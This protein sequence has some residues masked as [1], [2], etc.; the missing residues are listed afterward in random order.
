VHFY[1]RKTSV[2]HLRIM[3]LALF[4]CLTASLL[5][6]GCNKGSGALPP[7]VKDVRG[8]K[9][10]GRLLWNDQPLQHQPTEEI[11]VM[12]S[13]EGA[14]AGGVGSSANVK[15]D[16]GS[17]TIE[18]PTL[19]GVPAGR[20]KVTVSGRAYGQGQDRFEAMFAQGMVLIADVGDGD[21]QNLIIDLANGR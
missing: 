16:D 7:G 11:V 2:K 14:G 1:E 20:Y 18:G 10:S 9:V 17:F 15:P 3:L 21:G 6:V 5:A 13:Q 4:A 8:A 12:F 19:R